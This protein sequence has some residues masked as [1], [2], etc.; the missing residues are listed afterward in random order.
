MSTPFDAFISY[1]REDEADV[2]SLFVERSKLTPGLRRIVED[3]ESIGQKSIYL[4]WLKGAPPAFSLARRDYLNMQNEQIQ[5]INLSPEQY[6]YD[7]LRSYLL[8]LLKYDL[9]EK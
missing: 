5:K 3:I 7:A 4:G 8:G 9:P 6:N 1:N 2:R